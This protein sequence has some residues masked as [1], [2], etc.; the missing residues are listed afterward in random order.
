MQGYVRIGA[1]CVPRGQDCSE[2]EL[3]LGSA[4]QG[5]VAPSDREAGPQQPVTCVPQAPARLKLLYQSR[6]QALCLF[7]HGE[8]CLQAVPSARLA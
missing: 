8:G 4:G 1:G 3:P 6:D 7:E 2:R 5:S